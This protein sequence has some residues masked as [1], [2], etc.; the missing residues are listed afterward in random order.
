MH[1]LQL[2]CASLIFLFCKCINVSLATNYFGVKPFQGYEGPFYGSISS[3]NS[4][5]SDLV[6]YSNFSYYFDKNT[7]DPY[8]FISG[9][10]A[11]DN[12]STMFMSIQ[13]DIGCEHLFLF[14][15]DMEKKTYKQSQWILHNGHLIYL[16]FDPQRHRLFGLRDVSKL[17]LILEEYNTT[18]LDIIRQYTQQEIKKYASPQRRC[19]IFDYEENWIVEV[20]TREETPFVDAYFI[21]MD[22]NLVGIKEDL[23]TEF[24]LLSNINSL[25][26]MTYDIKRKLVLSTW[27][28]D[29]PH[30]DIVMTYMNPYTSKLTNQ[31]LLSKTPV[32]TE[33]RDVQAIY[34]PSTR[35]ILF[36]IHHV[37]TPLMEDQYWIILVEFDTMKMIEKKQVNTI[38]EFHT[39]ELFNL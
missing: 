22:L 27:Q 18:T 32:A 29:Y 7:T 28:R 1:R 34:D 12:S 8:Y 10:V 14:A 6:F 9:P 26:T 37:Y 39:W 25:C 5:T 2:L 3:Y 20:R 36:L 13:C 11:I 31:T 16:F 15:F 38:K 24:H 19:S 4:T 17:T 33:V 30:Q 23:V 35:Q 21:K